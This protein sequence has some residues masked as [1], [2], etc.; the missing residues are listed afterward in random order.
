MEQELSQWKYGSSHPLWRGKR[1][2]IAALSLLAIMYWLSAGFS[3]SLGSSTLNLLLL[4]VAV[5]L[6]DVVSQFYD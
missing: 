3:A 5:M 4:A 6:L 2:C 1:V